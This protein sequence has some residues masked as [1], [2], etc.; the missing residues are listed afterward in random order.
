VISGRYMKKIKEE[1]V[2]EV[3]EG[4]HVVNKGMC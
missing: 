1:G 2:V 4:V 3:Q